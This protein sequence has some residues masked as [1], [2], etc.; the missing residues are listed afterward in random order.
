M[1]DIPNDAPIMM[2]PNHLPSLRELETSNRQLSNCQAQEY[3][4]RNMDLK[5]KQKLER[6]NLLLESS[7]GEVTFT[8]TLQ[9]RKPDAK[10]ASE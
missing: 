9:A 3:A 5:M 10:S 4:Q 1:E 6:L 7:E 8:K 2:A